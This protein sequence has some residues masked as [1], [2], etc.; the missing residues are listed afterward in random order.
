MS[1]LVRALLELNLQM[2]QLMYYKEECKTYLLLMF[3]S[4]PQFVFPQSLVLQ[5]LVDCYHVCVLCTD[6]FFE[7]FNVIIQLFYDS[8]L[9][10]SHPPHRHNITEIYTTTE[11]S[12]SFWLAI[13][14]FPF[15]VFRRTT[16]SKNQVLIKAYKNKV[17]NFLFIIPAYKKVITH[18]IQLHSLHGSVSHPVGQRNLLS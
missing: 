16:I 4:F 15:N 3:F 1:H 2:L 8:P 12:Y 5:H 9:P 6:V 7:S 13:L 17:M 11:L 14:Y 18:K 10:P